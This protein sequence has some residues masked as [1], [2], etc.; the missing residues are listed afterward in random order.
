MV[1]L[2]AEI[3]RLIEQADRIDVSKTRRWG[4]VVVTNCPTN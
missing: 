3:D 4:A 1:R 2:Q